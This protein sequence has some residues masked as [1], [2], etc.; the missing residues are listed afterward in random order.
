M[1]KAIWKPKKK[2]HNNG[3]VKNVATIINNAAVMYCQQQ[4]FRWVA[5]MAKTAETVQ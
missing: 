4:H 2:K 5:T 1:K 3:D